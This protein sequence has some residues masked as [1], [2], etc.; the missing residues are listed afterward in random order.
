VEVGGSVAN[1]EDTT[2][3]F[4]RTCCTVICKQFRIP[5]G[6]TVQTNTVVVVD[7]LKKTSRKYTGRQK[8]KKLR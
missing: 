2:F 4:C 1:R 3:C 5:E 7:D 6:S 8:K